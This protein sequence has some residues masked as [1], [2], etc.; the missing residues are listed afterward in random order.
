MNSQSA[1]FS[2]N[3]MAN[4]LEVSRSGYN[5]WLHRQNNPRPHAREEE[6]IANAI[7]PIFTEHK[8]RFGSY[9]IHQELRGQGFGIS[10]KRVARIMKKKG[11]NAK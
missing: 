1:K 4:K 6:T 9:R 8:E 5:A 11:L 2:I 10:R 7:E 3:W